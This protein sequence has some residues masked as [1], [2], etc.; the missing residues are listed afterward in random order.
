[1]TVYELTTE[2][3]RFFTDGNEV[4]CKTMEYLEK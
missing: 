2:V 3:I 4:L 1:M